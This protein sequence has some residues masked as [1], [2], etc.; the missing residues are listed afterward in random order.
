MSVESYV[1]SRS[2]GFIYVPSVDVTGPRFNPVEVI[3][4][5]TNTLPVK[6]AGDTSQSQGHFS[7]PSIP[8]DSTRNS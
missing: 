8:K 4:C 3:V 1:H 2:L 6:S 7:K 5:S